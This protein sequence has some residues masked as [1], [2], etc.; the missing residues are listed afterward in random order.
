[1]NRLNEII[2]LTSDL[3]RFKSMH[4]RPDEI[5]A[6]ARFIMCWCEQNGIQTQLI[7]HNGIPSVI[8]MPAPG[9]TARLLLMSHIDVV[10][11]EDHMFEPRVEEDKLFGRGA[12]DDKYAVA[13][14]LI[15][16]RDRLRALR[17]K[18]LEQKDMALG[19]LI[20]GDEEIGGSN[21]AGYALPTIKA[22]FAVALDGGSPER[23]V[24][25][26]KGIINL[27]ITARGTAAHGA[28]PWL[29]EN[30]I[31][32]LI[33]DY[34]ALKTL[35]TEKNEEHW[36]RTVNFGIVRAGESINQVPDMAEGQFN[37]RYTDHDDPEALIEMIRET[38]AGEVEVLRI[39]TVFASPSSRYKD[40][41]MELSGAEEVQEHG[42]SDARYL[43]D[44]GMAGI[45]WGAEVFGSIHGANEH[46]SI[47]SIGKLTDTL[48][49]LV[50]EM[51][52]GI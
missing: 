32:V 13:L 9:S 47:S 18:G 26:E 34:Q 40:R 33:R 31:D 22:D 21:G 30:A 3:I 37:I 38:V 11:A 50:M 17:E 25:K 4:S 15:L 49:K 8:I 24:V 28:R 1:M 44:N 43:Q 51:E 45:V 19:V 39:D 23:M 2:Q 27:T 16:F 7:E 52:N 41:L 20:T 29:G 5:M 10:D 46:V 36:H 6:C 14:S 35:F 42:A 48:E 12:G